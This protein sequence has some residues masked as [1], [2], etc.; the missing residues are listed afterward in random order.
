MSSFRSL[1]PSEEDGDSD[2]KPSLPMPRNAELL[3]IE[4]LIIET[5]LAYCRMA[6]LKSFDTRRPRSYSATNS[7]SRRWLHSNFPTQS[8]LRLA[9]AFS[10]TPTLDCLVIPFR[11]ELRS[12]AAP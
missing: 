12:E 1:P 8:Q 11:H 7:A 4:Q 10:G 2:I 3:T 6:D 5:R 9:W